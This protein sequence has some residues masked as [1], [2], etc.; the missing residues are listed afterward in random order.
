M[1][2]L[3][4]LDASFLNMETPTTFGHVS[5]LII[6]DPTAGQALGGDA[7]DVYGNVR[8]TLEER[9]HLVEVYR[10][11][12]ATVPLGLDH[13]YWIDDPDLDLDYHVRE[14]AIP[15]PGDDR[16]LGEQIA[17]IVSR[18]LDRSRPLWEFYVLSGLA[19]GRVGLLT[20]IHHSTIDGVSGVELL[21]AIL[22]LA[23]EGRDV[24]A[25]LVPWRP[26]P[27]PSGVELLAR[28]C[29]EYLTR[30]QKLVQFQLRMLRMTAT[31]S[32]NP[33]FRRMALA[34]VP[35][36]SRLGLLIR[37]DSLQEPTLP[38]RPAPRTSFNRTI[39]SH[40]RF[41]MTTLKLSDARTVKDAFG[42]TLN[43]VVLELCAGA[44][45]RYLLA[46][47]E[48]PDDP[49]IAMVPISVRTEKDKGEY[50]NR[51]AGATCPL[52]TNLAAVEDRLLAIHH[53]MIAAKELQQAI[54]ADLL[55]DATQF[56]P[57]ALA[58]Q[59][60]RLAGRTRIADR[61]NP[62]VN[63]IVSNVPGPREPL[64]LS[65]AAMEHFYPVSTIAD[66]MGLNMTVQSYLDNLDFGLIAC[67]ELVPDLWDL[68]DHLV[69]EMDELLKA[70][71]AV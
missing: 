60:S 7:H 11:K 51:V 33:A 59:A 9:L 17:R 56:A 63:V 61:L 53:S 45:R 44:L 10:R 2:Q 34:A 28:T 41:A 37:D 14:I 69:D 5:S 48:L 6:L 20:K 13:P 54:P 50:S 30:P 12:L 67:R 58:A 25:P 21:H 68:C 19:G 49:L 18:P 46:H 71:A 3:S 32:G 70:A 16:Q 27:S 35:G 39:T 57:P 40:R 66:G 29:V 64:Y 62:P 43:D 31:V 36:L 42:V 4:G 52:H 23:P 55:T 24:D 15:A 26:E 65:G 38:D 1:K 8:R 47:D 22:D